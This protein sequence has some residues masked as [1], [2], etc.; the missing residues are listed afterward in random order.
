MDHATQM[1]VRASTTPVEVLATVPQ[2]LTE[3]ARVHLFAV[4]KTAPALRVAVREL[5]AALLGSVRLDSIKVAAATTEEL[6]KF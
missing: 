1:D 6:L 4:L 2:D 3:T 5:L